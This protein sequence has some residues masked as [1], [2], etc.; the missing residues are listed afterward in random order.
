MAARLNSYLVRTI[1]VGA[2]GGLLFGFDTAV[3]SGTTH[4]IT[5]IFGLTPGELGFTVSSA[6]WG[7]VLGA[8]FSG[9]LG[10]RIGSRN[11]LLLL[12][13]CYLISALGCAFA[14]NWAAL[15]FFRFVG[16]LGIGGSSVVGP[17]YIAEVSPAK[18]RGRMVGCFQINIVIGILVAYL[19]N[20]LIGLES[21][22]P[23]EWRW[24]FG[25]AAI[26]AILFLA[27]LVGNPP[28]PR[29]LAAAGRNEEAKVVLE[30]LGSPD[31][32]GELTEIRASLEEGNADEDEALFQRKY[33]NPILLAI[34][35]A[36]FN[37]LAGINA[38][39]YYSNYIFSMAG[40][41]NVSGNLQAV[42]I[43]GSNLVATF[44]AMSLIDRLG[45][46]SLLLI[47]SVG[48]VVCLSGVAGIF[49]RHV[50]QNLLIVCL[51]GFVGFFALSQGAVIW[52]Y[53]SEIFPN[54]V[55]AKGQSLGSS[56]HWLMNALISGV[57]PLLAARSQAYPF[58][59][60]ASMMVLQF[61]VVLFLFPET[62]GITLERMHER[63][64]AK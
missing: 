4:A 51:V 39:L 44:L 25:A 16:G 33:R 13:G 60:F 30:K 55:R 40:F 62:K 15:L 48:M 35:I 31:P 28:S 52:V 59:F 53:L 49:L 10:Q 24:Q 19:S 18:W 63:L 61:F 50:H 2:L 42:A 46:K 9:I 21:L 1:I 23:H 17:V 54:R 12:A 14:W 27:L 11:S 41:D 32:Q 45:R 20:Y 29:W 64:E 38:V 47:G 36:M 57:F 34:A 5:A 7:T 22:G 3:I 26:P 8:M 37:Q 56:T 58:V 6:L 43:G